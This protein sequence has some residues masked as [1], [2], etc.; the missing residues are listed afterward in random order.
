MCSDLRQLK[1]KYV[2][3]VTLMRGFHVYIEAFEACLCTVCCLPACRLVPERS[4][5]PLHTRGA[6]PMISKTVIS[7]VSSVYGMSA[8][9]AGR[10]W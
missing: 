5:C 3:L 7:S 6:H 8:V 2:M 10:L 1:L 4:L 9:S